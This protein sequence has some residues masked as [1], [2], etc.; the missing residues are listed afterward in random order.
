MAEKEEK[1]RFEEEI[2]NVFNTIFMKDVAI[3]T[4]VL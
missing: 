2:S 4:K 3:T 1:I